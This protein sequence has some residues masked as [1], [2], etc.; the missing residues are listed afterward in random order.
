MF[1]RFISKG[2][3]IYRYAQFY[4]GLTSFIII[5]ILPV[6]FL[7]YPR[8]VRHRIFLKMSS[9]INANFALLILLSI[10]S[11]ITSK[12]ILNEIFNCTYYETVDLTGIQPFPN[13]SYEYAGVHIPVE[14]IGTYNYKV[15]FEGRNTSVPEYKRGCVCKFKPCI[16][17]CCHRHR[18]DLEDDRKCIE[19]FE[20]FP[21]NI[22]LT[23]ESR[24]ESTILKQFVLQ[25]GIQIA[26][27]S[28]FHLWQYGNNDNWSLYEVSC[29][30]ALVLI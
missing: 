28:T 19:E 21:V 24:K 13:G 17:Y 11:Q 30:C 4:T 20:D 3:L 5:I 9:K 12:E 26:C 8:T 16:R 25:L 2:Y 10:L 14:Y 23:D 18:L 7:R 15:L 22:T 1:N 6:D 29:V 27:N